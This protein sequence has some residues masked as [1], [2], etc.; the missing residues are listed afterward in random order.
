MRSQYAVETSPSLKKELATLGRKLDRRIAIFAIKLGKIE[1][2][3]L[4]DQENY[5]FV[6]DED[7]PELNEKN[8]I[9]YLA[10]KVKIKTERNLDNDAKEIVDD[11]DVTPKTK[12]WKEDRA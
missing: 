1:S 5:R 8:R 12:R 6:K 11:E 7:I 3:R 10:S 4:N 2:M 9:E